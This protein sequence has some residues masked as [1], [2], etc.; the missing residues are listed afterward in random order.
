MGDAQ[1]HYSRSDDHQAGPV[2]ATELN[3]LAEAG[4]LRSDDLVW[5]E[6]MAEWVPASRIK[7]LE[8]HSS[9]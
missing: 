5:K 3:R 4:E 2:S 1:W 7:G 8:V 9:F 6:G